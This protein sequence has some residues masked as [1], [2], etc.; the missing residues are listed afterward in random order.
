MG[1][2]FTPTR[3]L[4]H[5]NV[6]CG[7]S[8][9]RSAHSGSDHHQQPPSLAGSPSPGNTQRRWALTSSAVGREPAAG[10]EAGGRTKGRGRNLRGGKKKSGCDEE[11]GKGGGEV[12]GGH[13]SHSL[14]YTKV[15]N[16]PVIPEAEVGLR[17]E[18]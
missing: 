12:G 10:A 14:S 18:E 13:L 1:R 15:Q 17:A 4:R 7:F 16:V 2:G 9:G 6:Q 8:C 5:T 11:G 3:E